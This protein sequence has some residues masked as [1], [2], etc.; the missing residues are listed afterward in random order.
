MNR[1]YWWEP[2]RLHIDKHGAVERRVSW[3]ELFYDLVFVVVIA[4]VAH[5]LSGHISLAG[6]GGY[7]LLF[8]ALWW[9][10]IGGTFYND[11]FETYDV[12]Y[13]ILTFAQMV[14]VAGMA[15]FAHDGVGE[16]SGRFALSYA[17]ARTIIT[18]MWF[19]GGWH[20]PSFRPVSNRYAVGFSL[21][22][23]LFVASVFVPPPLRFVMWGIGLAI[24]LLTPITTLRIQARLPIA[25][26]SKLPE[27]FGLFV[28]IVLGEANVGVIQG[29][30]AQEN[31]GLTTA[32]T[33]ILGLA[34]A[35]GL[36]WIYFDFVARRPPRPGIWWRLAWTYLHLPLVMGIAAIGAAILGMLV[37]Q[38][39]TEGVVFRLLGGAMAVTLIAIGL[40][41]LTLRREADEP[42]NSR[43]SI[44]LK[45]G[46][47]V[48]ALVLP[49][50]TD[51][52]VLVFLCV[53]IL[54]LIIHVIY[55]AYVWYHP[56]QVEQPQSAPEARSSA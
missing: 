25:G 19:R 30:A 37:P 21:S 55:G 54:L 16:L 23:A 42:T 5:Y 52:G 33:G 40:L 48:G 15:V 18:L 34:L 1:G 12:S 24:D 45:L 9:A 7:V 38:A 14:P 36:W 6:V 46:S 8:A 49:W 27:R 35:F 50:T 11:R 32:I 41:E 13:R 31:L 4:E 17:A 39:G 26:W 44:T 47:G 22:I 56:A 53:L 28:L 43:L 29:I 20:E 10:W 2:P 51:L 3:L